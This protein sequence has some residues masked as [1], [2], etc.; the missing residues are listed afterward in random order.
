M[1]TSHKRMQFD[2]QKFLNYWIIIFGWSVWT[3]PSSSVFWNSLVMGCSRRS[4]DAEEDCST[5]QGHSV[6]TLCLQS[7]FC[8][9]LAPWAVQLKPTWDVH[10]QERHELEHIVWTSSWVP[11]HADLCRS[12]RTTCTWL[13][14]EVYRIILD[15]RFYRIPDNT[16]YRFVP[17]NGYMVEP[18]TQILVG[19][20]VQPD[21]RYIP[22]LHNKRMKSCFC[23]IWQP[24]LLAANLS[25]SPAILYWTPFDWICFLQWTN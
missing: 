18:D 7:S 17:D 22:S 1:K 19:Y 10:G 4:A 2:D 9:L 3:G 23:I 12:G 16:G 25:W 20:P 8:S 13:D 5:S 11:I 15:M 6:R 24:Q 21:I 14:L